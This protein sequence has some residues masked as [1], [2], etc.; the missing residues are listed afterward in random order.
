MLRL[1]FAASVLAACTSPAPSTDDEPETV[2]E[3]GKAD[4][5]SFGRASYE[6]DPDRLVSGS[7]YKG[8][9]LYLE[10]YDGG[11][12]AW[13]GSVCTTYGCT[14]RKNQA[15]AYKLTRTSSGTT[16][17]RFYTTATSYVRYAYEDDGDTLWLRRSSTNDW[18]AMTK[19]ASL[20][21]ESLCDDTGGG[22]SDDDLAPDGTNCVCAAGT[23]WVAGSGCVGLQ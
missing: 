3:A 22:W 21:D 2:V 18:V 20:W 1:A 8:E 9:I 14:T 12:P 6:M 4:A 13:Q 15:G 10:L 7:W 23:V 16:Y 11:Q 19:V 5:P 17:F